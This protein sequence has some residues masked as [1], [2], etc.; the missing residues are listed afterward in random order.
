MGNLVDTFI[1]QPKHEYSG[2]L[3][4]EILNEFSNLIPGK[5]LNMLKLFEND[6]YDLDEIMIDDMYDTGVMD[7]F[8]GENKITFDSKYRS[9]CL[10][11]IL[12][13]QFYNTLC[14]IENCINEDKT[15]R[16]IIV[17]ESASLITEDEYD[18]QKSEDQKSV[19]EVCQLINSDG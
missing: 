15:N 6:H 19:D 17:S 12:R 10:K 18:N 2:I 5:Y 13:K 8:E 4:L 14:I 1:I 9:I 7:K 11:S 16:Y 3:V